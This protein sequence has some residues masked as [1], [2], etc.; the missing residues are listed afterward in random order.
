MKIHGLQKMTLLDYPSK[1]AAT[2]F[3]GGCDFC[4]PFCHNYELVNGSMAPL[5]DDNELFSFLEK[6]K[7]LLDGVVITGGE[8]CLHSSLKE[9]ISGIKEMGFLV[10]LDTNGNHPDVIK[11]LLNDKL[12]DYI[13]MDIKNSKEKY[14]R[15][16]GFSDIDTNII[17]ESINTIM[18]SNIDYEF[19]TTAIKQL[20][21][22]DDFDAI[23]KWIQGAKAYYIQQF[24]ERDTVPDKGLSS[25][26]KEEMDA[27]LNAAKKYVAE[28]YLRG[29]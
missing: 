20:H 25:P 14:A 23:G 6:R 10:K 2:V 8:P 22:I 18:N 27:Y 12:L 28:S 9:L 26:S 21:T 13:A 17:S 5:L 7:G 3:L 4:C 15:T 29:V 1:V 24:T 19:R 11:D 16:S